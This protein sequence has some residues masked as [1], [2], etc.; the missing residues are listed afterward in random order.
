M[1]AR[2]EGLRAR[3]NIWRLGNPGK[4]RCWSDFPAIGTDRWSRNRGKL[5]NPERRSDSIRSKPALMAFRFNPNRKAIRGFASK[6]NG[7]HENPP[8]LHSAKAG[9]VLAGGPLRHNRPVRHR[10]PGRDLL[11]PGRARRPA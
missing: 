8:N 1:V 11:D 4:Q 9:L 6:R 2:L 7:A 3:W 10:L 5:G